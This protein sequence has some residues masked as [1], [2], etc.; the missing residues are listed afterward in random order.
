MVDCINFPKYVCYILE[1]SADFVCNVF[2]SFSFQGLL[3][4]KQRPSV[5]YGS[6]NPFLDD[7]EEE[8]HSLSDIVVDQLTF[9]TSQRSKSKFGF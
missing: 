3:V 5:M 8:D 7:T 6:Q 2:I 1:N 9:L 4:E